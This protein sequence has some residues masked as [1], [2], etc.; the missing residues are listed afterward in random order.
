[1]RIIKLLPDVVTSMNLVCGIIG[2]IFAFNGRIDLAFPMMM[3]ASVFDFLDGFAA[4]ALDAYSDLGKELDSLCDLVSFGVLPSVMLY[5]LMNQCLFV[6][7][8]YCWIPL[9]ITIFSAVRLA[10]FNVDDRQHETFLGLATPACA[11]LSGALCYYIAFTPS[12]VLATWA[13]GPVF[14]PVLS[15]VLSALLVCE[16]PMFSL[17]GKL[18]G[19]LGMKLATL[20]VLVSIVIVLMVVRHMNWS[21]AVLATFAMYIIS[22]IV[23]AI[24]KV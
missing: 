8:W 6:N 3:L 7:E 20:V 16:I 21:F 17:K 24:A 18:K 13:A 9:V 5:N 10:K 14:I 12:S 2:V 23:Y 1:M 19:G 15:I 11:M 4:R 22:N